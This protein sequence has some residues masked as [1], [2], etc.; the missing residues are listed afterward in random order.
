MGKYSPK[1]APYFHLPLQSGNNR[2]LKIMNRTYTRE[3]FLQIVSKLRNTVPNISLSTDVIVGFPSETEEEFDD[4]MDILN[5]VRF[6]TVYSFLYSPRVGTVAAKMDDAVSRE[7]KNDRM[8]RLLALQDTVSLEKNLPYE[9]KC[10]RV[11]TDSL[12]MRNG[13]T[14]YTGRTDTNKL[15][16]FKGAETKIGEWVFVEI[17][18]ACPYDLIGKRKD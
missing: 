11:L 16:H 17:E 15:V 1:I 12:E 3:Q 7:E 13:D 18:K 8:S 9:G 2:I 4:T 14:V 5:T 6:D 10:V